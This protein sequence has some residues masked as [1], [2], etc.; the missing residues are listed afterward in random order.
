MKDRTVCKSCHNKSRRNNNTLTQNQRH[1]SSGNESCTSL[2]KPKIENFNKDNNNRTLILGFSNCS[3]TY[4]MNYI[5]LQ[6]QEL[7]YIITKSLNHYPNIK[8]QTSDEIQPLENYV[9][10]TCF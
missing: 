1:T 7:I 10:S 9:N 2:H 4:L 8:T 5:L 3:K 6:K